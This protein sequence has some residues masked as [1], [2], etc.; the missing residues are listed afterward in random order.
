M[1]SAESGIIM[2]VVV[3]VLLIFGIAVYAAQ[4]DRELYELRHR[5]TMLEMQKKGGQE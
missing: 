2:L 1:V 4:T 5:V 3:N